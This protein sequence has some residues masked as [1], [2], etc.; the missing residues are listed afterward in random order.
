V[1]PEPAW[2]PD[3]VSDDAACTT[4]EADGPGPA[5]RPLGSGVWRLA[6]C[7]G[8]PLVRVDI[9]GAAELQSG[10]WRRRL[11]GGWRGRPPVRVTF[12]APGWE[13]CR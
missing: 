6:W 13:V 5:D 11:P 10:A 4:G 8:A 7:S 9:D 3:E 2:R 12:S 1:F